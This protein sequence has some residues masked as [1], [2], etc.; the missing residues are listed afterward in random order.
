MA[1]T[2]P[3]SLL[4]IGYDPDSLKKMIGWNEKGMITLAG[5]LD[6]LTDQTSYK[7][8]QIHHSQEQLNE[9]EID[10]IFMGGT[11][12]I[13]HEEAK[14]LQGKNSL[15]IELDAFR[16]LEKII[17]QIS[18]IQSLTKKQKIFQ[19]ILTHSHEGVQFIDSD[20]IVQFVNP[21]FT[22]ITNIP[23]EERLGKHIDVVS[24]DGSLAKAFKTRASAL[25][26]TSTSP[27][28]N[29]ESIANAAPIFVEGE[30]IGAVT[31][32]QDVTEVKYLTEKLMEHEQKQ[33]VANQQNSGG[34]ESKYS[35]SHIIGQS[36]EIKETLHVAKKA[37]LSRST[38]LI[39]GESGTGK[40]LLA[41]AIHTESKFHDKP[42]VTVN[43]AAIPE[44]LL[45]SEL[46]GYEKGAFTHAV[47]QKAGKIE[48]ADGGTLFLDEIGD[49]NPSLQMKLLRVLQDKEFERL[50]G[51][52]K[53]QVDFRIIAATN[54]DLEN[55]VSEGKFREDLYYRIN[56]IR[57]DVPPLRKRKKDITLLVQ[58]LINRIGQ[59]IGFHPMQ[60]TE[61]GNAM[62]AEHEWPGNIREL[63]NFLERLMNESTASVIPD[64]LVRKHLHRMIGSPLA[65][66]NKESFTSS[67][68]VPHLPL[69][70]V[71]KE[72]I[73]RTLDH[74]G[75]SLEGKKE[76]AR[77]LGISISTLYNKIRDYQLE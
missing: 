20:G 41:H 74:Y 1:S 65:R 19:T 22:R 37:A 48:L 61:K 10:I 21:S 69:R 44:N 36:K 62:L 17:H 54:A 16:I 42:F 64:S 52:K 9:A 45:E 30:F 2:T 7:G 75:S 39:T 50:G 40:E 28:S 76:T 13:Y 70:D 12:E 11:D 5:V 34:Y 27:G 60:L 8:I 6:P 53:I 57:L 49:M 58:E 51:L 35:L 56:V 68:S 66:D 63:E 46:F 4:V 23:P 72:Y 25:R 43:C 26:Y 3:L 73:K 32:F 47:K 55:L 67:P 33:K 77:T 31:T 15:T 14:K 71:E 24:P 38:V 29:V 59:R 18:E